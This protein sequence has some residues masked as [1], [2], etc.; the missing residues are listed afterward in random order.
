MS[1]VDLVLPLPAG[2][3]PDYSV[4]PAGKQDQSPAGVPSRSREGGG[5]GRLP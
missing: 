4:A 2:G 1:K 3:A 5:Q